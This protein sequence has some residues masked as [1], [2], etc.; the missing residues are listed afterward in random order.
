MRLL[1]LPG[2]T[3]LA[4]T[5]ALALAA[6]E[7]DEERAQSHYE[8]AVTL[9]AEGES[10]RAAIELRNALQAN[11]SHAGARLEYA[12]LLRAE[13]NTQGAVG[14]YLRLLELDPDNVEAHLALAEMAMA[15]RDVNAVELHA[16]RAYELDPENPEIRALQASLDFREG[17]T[18]EAIAMAEGVLAEVPD[19]VAAHMVLI[20][21]RMSVSDWTGAVERVDAALA[22]RPN[23]EDLHLARLAALGQDMENPE[24]GEQL[25]RMVEL[26]PDNPGLRQG[27]LQ[28]HV[29]RGDLD[30][31]VALLREIAA[32]DPEAPEGHLSVAQFLLETEGPAA[33]RAELDA[34]IADQA[35]PR[36]YQRALA[37]LDF[38][39]GRR[40]EAIAGLRGILD[41]ET[42]DAEADAPVAP[43]V[44]DLQAALAQMLEATNA[45][46]E[47]EALVDEILAADPRHVDALK[48][49]ARWRIDADRTEEALLDLRAALTEAPRDPEIMTIMAMAHEREGA[50]EQVGERLAR[51][52]EASN[53]GRA[54]S[55][56]YARFLMREDRIGQAESIVLDALRR[57]PEDAEL[58]TMLGQIHLQRSDWTR[59][60]QVAGL[61]RGL[62]NPAATERAAGLEVAALQ[63]EGRTDDMLTM[64]QG[65][66]VEGEGNL[67]ARI[68][69]IQARIS[70]GDVA[71]AEAEVEALLA[72]DPD[73]LAGQLLHAGILVMKGETDEAEAIYRGVIADRPEVREPY[74]ILFALLGGLNRTDEAEAVLDEGIAA[75][76]RNS[77]LL[78]TKA[79]LSY[80][81]GDFD[82]AIALYEEIYDRDTSNVV[83]ANNLAS[84]ISTYRDDPESLD[85]AFQVA[86]RLRGTEVPQFQDTYGWILLRRGDNEQALTY[87]EPA[88]AALTGDPLVQ[89][90]LGM[91]YHALERWDDA[92]EALARAV[93][94]AGED[95]TLPQMAAARTHIAE[96][97]ARPED[98]AVPAAN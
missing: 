45:R 35:D 41:A 69:L 79:G 53:N 95:S 89:Y 67:P 84:V 46:D 52:V 74:Q 56:R 37:Q 23:D 49:R 43:E 54:E 30:A 77:E 63:G 17:K 6:C 85:R 16:R 15:S 27:L 86:R 20:A 80:M 87:L 36:P 24:I 91:A 11:G 64:L 94:I 76:N 8:R 2:F 40:D 93:E 83:I 55:L 48:M 81:R 38:A 90:H 42:A 34:L 57:A 44:R 25:V 68:G 5:S 19:N 33:A 73:G 1:R 4:L 65:L 50:T 39:E 47:S 18:D 71:G 22:L 75:T 9:V 72:E 66:A 98:E 32:Q 51:A 14:E 92:R 29:Q 26:F 97:D 13:D 31:A 88:A 62:N 12:R 21:E 70:S 96:I 78:N 61:L 82:N 7:S 10:E 60:R 3:A 28:W 59:A 58:L